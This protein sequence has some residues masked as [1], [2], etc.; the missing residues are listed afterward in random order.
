MQ[1]PRGRLLPTLPR[2]TNHARG[3]SAP[4]H[5]RR[6][7]RS[8]RQTACC[9][10]ALR[11]TDHNRPS[12]GRRPT[13]DHGPLTAALGGCAGRAREREREGEQQ[14]TLKQAIARH[15]SAP[16]SA[17]AN[18]SMENP[19]KKQEWAHGRNARIPSRRRWALRLR[20][21]LPGLGGSEFSFR[22]RGTTHRASRQ[23]KILEKQVKHFS[24]H[25][26]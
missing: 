13:T 24:N 23:A 7:C 14:P 6:S 19:V 25:F 17:F 18:P 9:A 4:L 21:P 22:V 15:Q 2:P 10:A 3:M 20:Q 11:S 26:T 5:C 8:L 16:A 12:T 1:A